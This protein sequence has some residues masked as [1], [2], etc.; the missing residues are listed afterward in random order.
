MLPRRREIISNHAHHVLGEGDDI[1]L[2]DSFEASEENSSTI[3][4]ASHF[5]GLHPMNLPSPKTMLRLS[6]QASI[7][8][9]TVKKAESF[10]SNEEV[11]ETETD[12]V[13]EAA[14]DRNS[15]AKRS[16]LKVVNR[17]IHRI[18]DTNPRLP[19]RMRKPNV[20]VR[21]PPPSLV[22]MQ[23]YQEMGEEEEEATQAN[24]S[25]TLMTLRSSRY[26]I[27]TGRTMLVRQNAQVF[28]RPSAAET[29]WDISS[30]LSSSGSS[31]NKGLARQRS[32]TLD[33]ASCSGLSDITEDTAFHR[34]KQSGPTL[35]HRHVVFTR[36]MDAY[37]GDTYRIDEAEESE[38]D[39]DGDHSTESSPA[40]QYDFRRLHSIDEQED[41]WNQHDLSDT[42][43]EFSSP[44]QRVFSDS[45]VVFELQRQQQWTDFEVE[46]PSSTSISNLSSKPASSSDDSGLSFGRDQRPSNVHNRRSLDGPQ[47][48]FRIFPGVKPRMRTHSDSFLSE[49]SSFGVQNRTFWGD[50]A[51]HQRDQDGLDDIQS[52]GVFPYFDVRDD[53]GDPRSRCHSDSF[54][55]P[56]VLLQNAK[57]RS[58]TRSLEE[59]RIV[60]LKEEFNASFQTQ[61]RRLSIA[62]LS[63][64][65]QSQHSK[66]HSDESLFA[67]IS[68][69]SSG[70]GSDRADT[71]AMSDVAEKTEPSE[72]LSSSRTLTA[73]SAIVAALRPTPAESKTHLPTPTTPSRHQEYYWG[74]ATEDEEVLWPSVSSEDSLQD[75]F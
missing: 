15:F 71:G 53:F 28:G 16:P 58:R 43:K 21:L 61:A 18:R 39:G 8:E 7:R 6:K 23:Q 2:T 27:G 10:E 42:H 19:W 5:G 33:N 13:A 20:S 41:R 38:S 32:V 40:G 4:N 72:E 52:P 55:D 59:E 31:S 36:P 63:Q 68:S 57:G 48:S 67:A 73:A 35:L 44:R 46:T 34:I 49:A 37:F 47:H 29:R 14:L 25:V 74:D 60:A 22:T 50:H 64:R 75:L 66:T 26:N 51:E 9:L 54:R 12:V 3:A 56:P 45:D 11:V 24:D 69:S 62:L 1:H 30:S 70:H 65:E 17:I